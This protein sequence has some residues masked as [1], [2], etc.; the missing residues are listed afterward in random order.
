MQDIV[1]LEAY[2]EKNIVSERIVID[3][4]HC[5]VLRV[6]VPF[7]TKVKRRCKHALNKIFKMHDVIIGTEMLQKPF[8]RKRTKTFMQLYP[9]E[10]TSFFRRYMKVKDF[11]FYANFPTKIFLETICALGKHFPY[12]TVYTENRHSMLKIA[13]MLYEKI[14]LPLCV[15]TIDEMRDNKFLFQ[16]DETFSVV[17]LHEKKEYVDVEL[18]FS[19]SLK[20]FENLPLYDILCVSSLKDAV[21]K[22]MKKGDVKII[23]VISK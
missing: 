3:A 1:V 9:A 10:C 2:N 17:D 14:G 22:L 21:N 16:T 7:K 11:A 13:K 18:S 20:P 8:L 6:C 5:A 23:G 19:G 12:I 15:K 4:L